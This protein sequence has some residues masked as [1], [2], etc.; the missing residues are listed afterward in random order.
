M[1]SR[2][3]VCRM[4]PRALMRRIKQLFQRFVFAQFLEKLAGLLRLHL[5]KSR[6]QSTNVDS[7][8]VIFDLGVVDRLRFFTIKQNGSSMRVIQGCMQKY[9]KRF[10]VAPQPK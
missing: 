7:I 8:V 4:F 3:L 2:V 10:L 6:Q 9:F 5:E 1:R